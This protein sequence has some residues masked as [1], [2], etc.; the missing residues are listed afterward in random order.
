M[1][2]EKNN[3]F[4]LEYKE[5][6]DQDFYMS[7]VPFVDNE[8]QYMNPSQYVKDTVYGRRTINSNLRCWT[9]IV[10]EFGFGKTS[11][12]L[13]LPFLDHDKLYIYVP[14]AQF[15]SDAFT[16]EATLSKGIL[17][18]LN[19]R[20]LE[21]SGDVLTNLPDKLLALALTLLLRSNKNIVLL[22][23][24]LD[25]HHK[26]YTEKGLVDIFNCAS[27]FVCHSIF[28]V[29]KEFI[30]ERHG[31]F[32]YAI[33]KKRRPTIFHLYLTEW[34]RENIVNYLEKEKQIYSVPSRAIALKSC[35]KS[36]HQI[37]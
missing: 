34:K 5:R 35:L 28:S 27:E 10:S 25:E 18:I 24:G 6:M 4:R 22:Y 7:D 31:N 19:E 9:F 26:A 16:N 21:C 29:R 15:T 14:I 32:L 23:D 30:D 17:S 3:S 36:M 12:L 20:E 2:E 8:K 37:P 1:I 33:G 11:L 13:N